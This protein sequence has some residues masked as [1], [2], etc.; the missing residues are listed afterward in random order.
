MWIG[1]GATITSTSVVIK[2]PVSVAGCGANLTVPIPTHLP[3][4]STTTIDYA[5]PVTSAM[6]KYE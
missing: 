1:L 4:V 3:N 2:P 5:N 6:D